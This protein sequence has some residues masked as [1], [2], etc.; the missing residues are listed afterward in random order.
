MRADERPE[1]E[2]QAETDRKQF[3]VADVLRFLD[4]VESAFQ[5]P[6]EGE[7]NW[8]ND[9]GDKVAF[10]KAIKKD[11]GVSDRNTMCV[12]WR[13]SICKY[14]ALLGCE[15]WSVEES[16]GMRR[17]FATLDGI[18]K[19]LE[20]IEFNEQMDT[21]PELATNARLRL[22]L[23]KR[24]ND[25]IWELRNRLNLVATSAGAELSVAV[26]AA[27]NLSDGEPVPGDPQNSNP[28]PP[29]AEGNKVES[30]VGSKYP[31]D[32]IEMA[33]AS[34]PIVSA[35][36]CW[37]RDRRNKS[38]SFQTIALEWATL[39]FSDTPSDRQIIDAFQNLQKPLRA[40]DNAPLIEVNA[41]TRLVSMK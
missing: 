32:P 11:L 3:P 8:N 1:I 24:L 20:K 34:K 18:I 31:D 7:L 26:S 35:R 38:A 15:G 13:E 6:M 17:R 10:A 25:A 36:Y 22:G 5:Q 27:R 28:N 2:D 9:L 30:L 14:I 41:E 37:L 16:L 33:L 12:S 4:A 29:A 19:I 39:K 23:G 40:I 21:P